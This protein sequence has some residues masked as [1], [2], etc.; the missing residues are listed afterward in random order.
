MHEWY[1]HNMFKRF[2]KP[3]TELSRNFLIMAVS[4]AKLY[5]MLLPPPTL[6]QNTRKYHVAY[7]SNR[8]YVLGILCSSHTIA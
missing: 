8:K 7:G 5:S 3:K 2:K 6:T 1:T 4:S